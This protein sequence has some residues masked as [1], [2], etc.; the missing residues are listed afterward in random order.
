V[1]PNR[2]TSTLFSNFLVIPTELTRL[3]K[4]EGQQQLAALVHPKSG[5]EARGSQSIDIPVGKL[6]DKI[7]L[8]PKVFFELGYQAGDPMQFR[9]DGRQLEI[10]AV[11]KSLSEQ[12]ADCEVDDAGI[13]IPPAW[14]IQAFTGAPDTIDHIENGKRSAD[15]YVDLYNRLCGDFDRTERV[16]DFGCGCGRVLSRMPGTGKVRYFGVDL[17]EDAIEWLRATMPEGT[18]VAGPPMPPL[19]PGGEDFDLVYAVSVLTHLAQEQEGAWLDEWHRLLRPGGHVIATF[20]GEDWVEQFAYENQKGAIRE[21]WRANGGFC[22]QQHRYWEGIF[23][24]FYSG[25]YQTVDYVR[26]TWGERFEIL[27][28]EPAAG[29]PNQQNTVVM[30]KAP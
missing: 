28:I 5:Q 24:A 20:R 7:A 17:R 9:Y 4:S 2:A 25:T 30:K 3:I 23:P 29:T 19:D 22:Y 8:P 6:P 18:F 11:G 14:L 1:H 12:V 13:R 10:T 21:E 26:S 15:Y 27:A 16:L